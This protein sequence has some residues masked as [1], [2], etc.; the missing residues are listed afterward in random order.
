L[1]DCLKLSIYEAKFKIP[2]AFYDSTSRQDGEQFR[3][4]ILALNQALG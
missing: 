1:F 3:P 2:L 4:A